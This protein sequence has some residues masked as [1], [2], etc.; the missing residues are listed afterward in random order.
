MP[1]ELKY[2]DDNSDR[3]VDTLDFETFLPM[4]VGASDVES[5]K[6]LYVAMTRTMHNLY[7]MYST[8][9]IGAPLLD[10]PPKLYLKTL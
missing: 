4:Y 7:V 2:T 10:V 8:P 9:T 5:K 3:F 6:A 1:C